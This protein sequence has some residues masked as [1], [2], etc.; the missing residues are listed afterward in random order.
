VITVKEVNIPL[1]ILGIGKG[2]SVTSLKDD[3]V[4]GMLVLF[5]GEPGSAFLD[6]ASFKKM[7]QIKGAMQARAGGAAHGKGAADA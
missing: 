7:V 1:T 3:E 5:D 6:W 4:D 2:R